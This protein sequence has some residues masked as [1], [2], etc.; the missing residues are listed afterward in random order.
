MK[1]LYA[2][3]TRRIDAEI[4]GPSTSTAGTC[5]AQSSYHT[6][7]QAAWPPEMVYVSPGEIHSSSMHVLEVQHLQRHVKR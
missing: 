1:R 2:P 4:A 3:Y 6:S 7:D 5:V